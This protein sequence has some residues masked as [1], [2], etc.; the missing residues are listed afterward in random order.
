MNELIIA[1]LNLRAAITTRD[2][3]TCCLSRDIIHKYSYDKILQGLRKIYPGEYVA[4]VFGGPV[5]EYFDGLYKYETYKLYI[6]VD[7]D[8]SDDDRTFADLVKK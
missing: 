5:E 6:P 1:L 4:D 2:V 8:M 7:V 3:K